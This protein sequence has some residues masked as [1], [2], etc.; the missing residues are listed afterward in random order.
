LVFL[1]VGILLANNNNK[2]TNVNF[3]FGLRLK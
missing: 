1:S 3:I 2:K